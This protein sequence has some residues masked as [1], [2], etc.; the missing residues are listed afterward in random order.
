MLCEPDVH[1]QHPRERKRLQLQIED[2]QQKDSIK[3]TNINDL[4]HL[5]AGC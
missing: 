4:D 3:T 2:E 1:H 5:Q